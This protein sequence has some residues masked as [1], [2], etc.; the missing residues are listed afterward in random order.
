MLLYLEHA[1]ME[2]DTPGSA[3][4]QGM[5]VT[6]VQRSPRKYVHGC[7]YVQRESDTPG[8]AY[9]HEMCVTQVQ[10]SPRM[11]VHGCQYVQRESQR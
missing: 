5:C 1:G 6:Q 9:M 8:S 7:Q 3:Y 11:H 10:R 2:S 4:M